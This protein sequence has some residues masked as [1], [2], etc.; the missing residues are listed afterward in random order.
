M[1]YVNH[2]D[3][4][5]LDGFHVR[6]SVA[7]QV[8]PVY[9]LFGVQVHE[10]GGSRILPATVLG[11]LVDVAAELERVLADLSMTSVSNIAEEPGEARGLWAVDDNKR[12]WLSADQVKT[13]DDVDSEC[14]ADVFEARRDLH[15]R[16]TRIRNDRV[17]YLTQIVKQEFVVHFWNVAAGCRDETVKERPCGLWCARMRSVQS[18]DLLDCGLDICCGG[19]EGHECMSEGHTIETEPLFQIWDV[20]RLELS[21]AIQLV[22][23]QF[24]VTRYSSLELCCIVD[25]CEDCFEHRI[26][27]GDILKVDCCIR[28]SHHFVGFRCPKSLLADADIG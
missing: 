24:D 5:V 2:E 26:P 4:L 27:V 3:V 18:S 16:I 11:R 12:S 1:T 19:V 15:G 10:C 14:V 25:H 23:C 28:L 6:E 22:K 8:D 21:H 9:L 7:V 17:V 13:S 20:R